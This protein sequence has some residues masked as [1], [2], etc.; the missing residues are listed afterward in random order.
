MGWTVSLR[1]LEQ[2]LM[3]IYLNLQCLVN[4]YRYHGEHREMVTQMSCTGN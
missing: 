2:D 4:V 3:E 1:P